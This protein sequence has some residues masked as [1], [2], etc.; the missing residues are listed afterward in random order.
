MANT[1]ALEVAHL[2]PELC[3]EHYLRAQSLFN[4][5]GLCR[6]QP[7]LLNELW[8]RD[9]CTQTELGAAMHVQPATIT[10][11]LQRMESSGLLERRPDPDDLRVMRVYL[12]DA[13]RAVQPQVEHIWETLA[14]EALQDFTLEEQLLLRRFL[15][16]M[17]DNLRHWN[18]G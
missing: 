1:S 5:L 13:G 16:Q 8:S 3:R 4:G 18:R 17:R 14:T 2:L 7:G 6:G 11:M 12:T 15:I 10:K 9:G